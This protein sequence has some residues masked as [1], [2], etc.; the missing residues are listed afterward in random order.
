MME[1]EELEE[2]EERYYQLECQDRER[3]RELERLMA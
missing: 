1:L 2:L 3:E